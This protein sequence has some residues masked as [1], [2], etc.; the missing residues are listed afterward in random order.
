[1]EEEEEEEQCGDGKLCQ[2]PITDPTPQR[3]R[4]PPLTINRID[5]LLLPFLFS[6]EQNQLPLWIQF[7][8]SIS[9]L[10]PSLD[11]EATRDRIAE[12]HLGRGMQIGK[13]SF[14]AVLRFARRLLNTHSHNSNSLLFYTL[15]VDF[16]TIDAV[17]SDI[18]PRSSTTNAIAKEGNFM[19]KEWKLEQ[20]EEMKPIARKSRVVLLAAVCTLKPC[21]CSGIV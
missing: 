10:L 3:N 5:L 13:L 19:A 20:E 16:F 7:I 12:R 1:M 2:F 4:A 11:D 9:S 18:I 21:C 15:P 14:L 17:Y 6:L 8:F